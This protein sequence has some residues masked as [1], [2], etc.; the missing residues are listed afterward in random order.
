MFNPHC[1][2]TKPV[3]ITQK[4][5]RSRTKP[6]AAGKG[7]LCVLLHSAATAGLSSRLL[8][9]LQR[10]GEHVTNSYLLLTKQKG[11]K[12]SK[13][14]RGLYSYMHKVMAD[15][16]FLF[17]FFLIPYAAEICV[18]W[19]RLVWFIWVAG[20]WGN[21]GYTSEKENRPILCNLLKHLTLVS[22]LGVEINTV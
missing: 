16:S 12:K 5:G 9:R 20:A 4:L 8:S 11:K 19:Y 13:T 14:G 17:R 6:L 22:S 1:M 21:G 18:P 10:G 7:F 2:A 15:F 3:L